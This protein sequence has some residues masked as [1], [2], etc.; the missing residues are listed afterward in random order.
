MVGS[1]VTV[2]FGA[3]AWSGDWGVGTIVE[4]VAE[5]GCLELAVFVTEEVVADAALV[6]AV[7]L[8]VGDGEEVEA[9]SALALAKDMA[10]NANVR[11]IRRMA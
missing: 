6:L 7:A 5:A 1:V 9:G 10:P 8:G 11:Q 2:A 4:V 3:E